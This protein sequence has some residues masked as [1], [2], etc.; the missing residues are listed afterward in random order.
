[1]KKVLFLLAVSV[2]FGCNNK[3][4]QKED[5]EAKFENAIENAQSSEIKVTELF[6]GFKF[7]MTESQVY[8]HID[9]LETIGKVYIDDSKSFAYD[10]T[11][12]QGLI[13][14]IGFVP[15]FQDDG[16][17][18]MTYTLEDKNFGSMGSEHSI[19]YIA[20]NESDKNVG[21]ST[22]T[23]G[24]TTTDDMVIYK[25]K[26]N[27]VITFKNT[28][29]KQSVMVYENAPVSKIAESEKE[30]KRKSASEQSL[31]EF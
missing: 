5:N 31:S 8:N 6:L 13:I 28:L 27:L 7:G 16:L 1:M 12:P 19:M 17:Y 3:A 15:A 30:A 23:T 2:M 25:I 10:F 14:K 24:D 9:S 20:F 18:Q 29:L 21:F 11:Q 4:K 26:D 22:Y